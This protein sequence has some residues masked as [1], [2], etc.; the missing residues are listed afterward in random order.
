MDLADVHANVE[1]GCH[2]ASMGGTWMAVVYGVAGMREHNGHITFHPRL[3]RIERLAFHLTIQGQLLMVSIDRR[4]GQ[5]TYLLRDGTGLAI[6]HFAEEL[7]LEPG[8][9]VSRA[10]DAGGG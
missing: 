5:V 2:I 4:D 9:P 8:Q 3:G 6:G 1:Q 10:L 7:K